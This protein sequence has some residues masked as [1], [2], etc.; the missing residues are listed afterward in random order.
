MATRRA[1]ARHPVAVTLMIQEDRRK[2]LAVSGTEQPYEKQPATTADSRAGRRS[3]Q[4]LLDSAVLIPR[5][6]VP[7]LDGEDKVAAHPAPSS[8]VP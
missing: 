8:K 4:D 1:D 2:H 5:F 6:R 7:M 3:H